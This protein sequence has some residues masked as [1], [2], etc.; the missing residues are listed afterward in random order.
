MIVKIWIII[1]SLV[2]EKKLEEIFV[3]V[4]LL[5]HAQI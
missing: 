2:M 1:K 5:V 3:T 4:I